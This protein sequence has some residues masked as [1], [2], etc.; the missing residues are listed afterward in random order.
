MHRFTR[1]LARRF[2]SHSALPSRCPSCSVPLPTQLPACPKC[3]F[4]SGV[5]SAVSFYDLF[6]LPYDPNP[7]LVDVPTLRNR[8][9]QAQ[10]VCHPDSWAT[11]GSVRVSL[12]YIYPVLTSLEAQKRHCTI[13]LNTHQSS[14][15]G[16]FEAPFTCRVYSEMQWLPD[17]GDRAVG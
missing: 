3:A 8:F 7:F 9:R 6:R 13:P 2:L 5:P 14:V 10:A 17:V 12:I 16:P 11:K 15:P 1:Q 4:I